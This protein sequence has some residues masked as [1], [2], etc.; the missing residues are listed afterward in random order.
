MKMLRSATMLLGFV[1]ILAAGGMYY[2]GTI[3]ASDTPTTSVSPATAAIS[4]KDVSQQETAPTG[5]KSALKALIRFFVGENEEKSVTQQAEVK[6]K[7]PIRVINGGG[8]LS[9]KRNSGRLVK[10]R[11]SEE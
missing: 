4:A 10:A 8:A 7:A 1:V 6:E 11:Q 2:S 9:G 3:S 5:K